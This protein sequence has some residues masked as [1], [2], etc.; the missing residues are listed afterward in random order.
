M[1]DVD[2]TAGPDHGERL[3]VGFC[4][5]LRRVGLRVPASSTISF[6]E[7]LGLVGVEQRDAVYWAGR[8]TLVHRPEDLNLFDR[9]FAAYWQGRV[10]ESIDIE[11]TP[12]PVTLALDIA[13]ER[14]DDDETH[15][16]TGDIQ[17]VRFSD[18]E[19]L[20][21]KDF[22]D[23][24]DEELAELNRLMARLRFTTHRRLSRRHVPT[25]GMGERPDLRRTVRWALRHQGEPIK[26]AYTN[27]ATRPR[28][29][30]MILDVS[31]SME[32]YARALLRFGH[33]AV[34]ARSK[35]EIFVLGTPPDP[36]DQAPHEPRP[37]LGHPSGHAPG[38]GLGRRDPIG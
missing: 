31:G 32:S 27:P 20:T 13:D 12:P 9:A 33:A 29:L 3:A 17:P 30:V 36:A 24:N 28:R 22:A 26:R 34:V 23:C 19:V 8:S 6:T 14:N 37:R 18:T 4:R 35:V 16:P 10:G 1:T 2:L 25:R 5:L 15:E 7:A 38:Q 21:S 11:G